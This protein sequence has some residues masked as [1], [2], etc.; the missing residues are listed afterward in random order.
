MILFQIKTPVF[1]TAALVVSPT[2]PAALAG[3]PYTFAANSPTAEVEAAG[4]EDVETDAA[5]EGVGVFEE[6]DDVEAG[7]TLVSV[8]PPPPPLFE[9]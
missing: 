8:K 1:S 3:K 5:R 7:F 6:E 4:V 2:T 9:P